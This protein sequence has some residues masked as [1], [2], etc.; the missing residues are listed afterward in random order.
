MTAPDCLVL[1]HG[2]TAANARDLLKNGFHPGAWRHGANGGQRGMFYLSTE[3]EDARWFSNEAG[4]DVVLEVRVD[5]TQLIVDPEDSI[6]ETVEEELA[7]Q[8]PGKLATRKPIG[9]ASFRQV[10]LDPI[11]GMVF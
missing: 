10:D 9:A 5:R 3:M 8:F 1:Y 2:T 4:D 6:G 7:G 11:L